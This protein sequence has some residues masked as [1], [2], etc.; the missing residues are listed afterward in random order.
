MRKSIH[1]LVA[2]VAVAG[3]AAC[4]SNDTKVSS[5]PGGTP[6]IAVQDPHLLGGMPQACLDRTVACS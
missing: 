3:L 4:S 2:A 1:L 6:Q 5:D